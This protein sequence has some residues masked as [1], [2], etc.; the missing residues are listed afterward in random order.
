[1]KKGVFMDGTIPGLSYCSK[2]QIK[3]LDEDGAFSYEDSEFLT[4]LI[5]EVPIGTCKGK[6]NVTPLDFYMQAC[7]QEP[8]YSD[9]CVLNTTRILMAAATRGTEAVNRL[10]SVWSKLVFLDEPDDFANQ[11]TV[12]SFLSQT[13][14]VLPSCASARNL[15]RRCENNIHIERDAVIPLKD[16]RYPVAV[17]IRS[18]RRSSLS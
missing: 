3:L 2:G 6:Q 18:F 9:F 15:M 16:G 17:F 4:F 5:G 10:G 11:K 12:Q 8:Q 14:V 1:M 7:R 13:G